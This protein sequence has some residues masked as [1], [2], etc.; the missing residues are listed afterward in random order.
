MIWIELILLMVLAIISVWNWKQIDSLKAT[1]EEPQQSFVTFEDY[2]K[3]V[4]ALNDTRE[5]VTALDYK[6]D[7]AYIHKTYADIT[8]VLNSWSLLLKTALNESGRANQRLDKISPTPRKKINAK[9][10]V[11]RSGKLAEATFKESMDRYAEALQKQE[12]KKVEF[13]KEPNDMGVHNDL[14]LKYR[15]KLEEV[16]D[17][18]Q[19]TEPSLTEAVEDIGNDTEELE[20]FFER[21]SAE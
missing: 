1:Q 4:D 9:E 2:N 5:A 19:K 16:A 13:P 6:D 7:V 8:K 3:L 10:N 18:F 11:I 20:A 14:D 12:E 17:K 15:M 21:K